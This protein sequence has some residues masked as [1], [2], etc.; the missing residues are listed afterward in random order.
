VLLSGFGADEALGGYSRHRAAFARGGW[1]ALAAE[2]ALDA[3]RLPFRNCGRDD[4]VAADAGR[5]LRLPFLD[6][7]VARA[8]AAAPLRL[9]TEP[10]LPPGE[11]DKRALRA[12]A[13]ALGLPGA[14][15]AVKR[16]LQFGSR[17]AAEAARADGGA[18]GRGAGAARSTAGGA[19]RHCGLRSSP[20]PA[21]GG[22]ARAPLAE[23]APAAAE[24][25]ASPAAAAPTRPKA[26]S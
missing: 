9:L 5:E 25:P 13:R 16:A 26:A 7:A 20:A 1:R 10:R 11:G 21:S 17:I 15:R 24:A 2:L 8:V 18:G 22:A 6:E 3:A 14:A 19:A 4:R 23:A 12:A